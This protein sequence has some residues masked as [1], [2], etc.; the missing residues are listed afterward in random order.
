M[1]ILIVSNLDNFHVNF[2]L[3]LIDILHKKWTVDLASKGEV[4]FNNVSR[5]YNID[6]GRTPFKLSN[7]LAYFS[8]RK[9]FKENK[10]DVIYC[11]TPVVGFITR[12][13]SIKSRPKGFRIIYSAHGY[14]FYKGNNTIKNKIFI[15][16]EKIMSRYTDVVITMNNEDFQNSKKYKLGSSIV[17]VNGV[18][19]D[20]NRFNRVL[21]E[22][23]MNL[24]RKFSFNEEDFILIYPAEF[25]LRKN[26][27]LL[28]LI[29]KDLVG[30]I[31][32]IKLLLVGRGELLVQNK[33]I[34]IDLGI[35]DY[36][37]FLDYRNDIDEL[38]KMSDLLVS[39]SISEGLPINV[40]E[41]LACGIPVVASKIRGHID[42]IVDNENG[43]LFDLKDKL[44]AVNSILAIFENKI[45][46]Q[47]MSVLARKSIEKYSIHN[48]LNEY[49]EIIGNAIK[50]K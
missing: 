4:T 10:Y 11:N 30:K 9:I 17:A 40:Q 36:V 18:G 2:H 32:N 44:T 3:P 21:L 1:R 43:L 33:Q 27:K 50:V 41:A 38:L 22:E 14:S 48:V 34:A 25:T 20:I 13:A 29:L 19:I 8:L 35:S 24:R 6:F 26:Q 39:T 5:K 16:L 28:L 7:I 49:M 45:L 23:K 12:L 15:F 47:K 42:L 46:L 37:E 31:Q